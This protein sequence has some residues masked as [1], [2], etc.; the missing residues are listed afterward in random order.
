MRVSQ[1][2]MPFP[3]VQELLLTHENVS[4]IKMELVLSGS[5]P[6]FST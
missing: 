6:Y 2:V 4:Y 5:H 1:E 3:L